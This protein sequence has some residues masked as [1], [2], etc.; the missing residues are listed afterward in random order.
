MSIKSFKSNKNDIIL[1]SDEE[2]IK[3]SKIFKDF[4]T[5]KGVAHK[6]KKNISKKMEIKDIKRNI[7]QVTEKVFI[8]KKK[9]QQKKIILEENNLVKT[10][11][12][13]KDS[14]FVVGIIILFFGILVGS[15]LN[16]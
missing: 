7:I 4:Y 10:V 13:D 1:D 2:K 9:I 11:S 14:H 6:L 3:A 5:A 16:S 15:L 12:K 8:I